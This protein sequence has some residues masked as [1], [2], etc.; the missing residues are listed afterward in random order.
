MRRIAL[1]FG[2]IV[3]AWTCLAEEEWHEFRSPS[4]QSVP[5]QVVDYVARVNQVTLKLKNGRLKKV[6]PTVFVEED[7]AYIKT[8]AATQ[9]FR[10][11]SSFRILLKKKIAKKWKKQIVVPVHYG[12]E[13]REENIGELKFKSIVYEIVLDN[14]NDVPFENLKVEYRIFSEYKGP[15]TDMHSAGWRMNVSGQGVK[16]SVGGGETVTLSDKSKKTVTT[17]PMTEVSQEISGDIV[18]SSSGSHYEREK[19]CVEGIWVRVTL[20]KDGQTVVRETFS[21][22]TLKGK[23][24]WE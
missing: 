23:H 11:S 3:L 8:W 9:G 16:E 17:S 1:F 14:R 19:T 24:I 6:K 10:K 18:S 4:G 13:V 20:E 15:G 5:A 7:Q 2:A 22:D 21:P 12:S